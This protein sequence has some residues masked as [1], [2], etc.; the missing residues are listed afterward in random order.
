MAAGGAP[1]PT[2]FPPFI[3]TAPIIFVSVHGAYDLEA[4]DEPFRVPEGTLLIETVD[5]GESCYTTMDEPLWN[6]L[7]GSNRAKLL[8]YMKGRVDPADSDKDQ[9]LYLRVFKH[10][11]VY[12]PGDLVY[13]RF[14]VI[15]GGMNRSLLKK[16]E[17]VNENVSP[18]SRKTFTNM[19]FYKFDL[20]EPADVFPVGSARTRIFPELRDALIADEDKHETYESMIDKL[21]V[22]PDPKII[23][24][25]CCGVR[26]IGTDAQFTQVER[27]QQ[28]ADLKFMSKREEYYSSANNAAARAAKSAWNKRGR[29]AWKRKTFL[30]APGE[31]NAE[32]ASN[33]AFYSNEEKANLTGSATTVRPK[34]VLLFRYIGDNFEQVTGPSGKYFDMAKLKKI[35]DKR[36]LYVV[37]RNG[38][39]TA[40]S[41]IHGG[42]RSFSR[43]VNRSS[44]SKA[45]QKTRRKP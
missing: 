11:H 9:E 26:N 27:V 23:V 25:G 7:Q 44:R 5:I 1:D 3:S 34:G 41:A 20:G 39:L 40:L 37:N 45:R 4:Y 15:G 32:K 36:N 19:G 30:R 43:K 12:E 17:R 8:T 6:L 14:L 21:K 35:T 24:F 10:I 42:S 18:F 13:N 2:D 38:S 22:F 31:F 28:A 33:N 16:K 29:A